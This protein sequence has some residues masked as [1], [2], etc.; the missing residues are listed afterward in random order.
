MR[1]HLAGIN[2][3]AGAPS[4]PWRIPNLAG[5]ER[6]ATSHESRTA[7]PGHWPPSA[8]LA[9][10]SSPDPHPSPLIPRSLFPVPCS[11]PFAN[12]KGPMTVVPPS[13]VW[14]F[15]PRPRNSIARLGLQKQRTRGDCNPLSRLDL[16]KQ[17]SPGFR[18]PVSGSPLPAFGSYP[19][20]HMQMRACKTRQIRVKIDQKGDVF[21]QKA[22]KKARIPSCPS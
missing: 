5:R 10:S 11:R 6:R 19:Q 15:T 14:N 17:V 2:D 4:G 21:R 22:I 7:I 20:R 1:I 12:D 18:F 8:I 16:Q 3:P 9:V 13:A